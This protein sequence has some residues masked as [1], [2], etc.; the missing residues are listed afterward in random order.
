M[1]L[2][3]KYYLGQRVAEVTMPTEVRQCEN[4]VKLLCFRTDTQQADVWH[5]KTRSPHCSV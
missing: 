2:E 4:H 3:S 1:E 5:A